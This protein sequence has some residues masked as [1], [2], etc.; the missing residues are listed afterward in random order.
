MISCG[1]KF[2]EWFRKTLVNERIIRGLLVIVNICSFSLTVMLA[3][4][5]RDIAATSEFV[6]LRI[7]WLLYFKNL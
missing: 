1:T 3:V 4:S 5:C 6:S 7:M 2:S